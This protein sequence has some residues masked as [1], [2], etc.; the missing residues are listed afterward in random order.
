MSPH[1]AP[2]AAER[3]VRVRL[4]RPT[5]RGA[6]RNLG[7]RLFERYGGYEGALDGWLRHP[8]VV[9]VVA[10]AGRGGPRGF[11][12]IGRQDPGGAPEAYLLAIG[13]DPALQASGWGSALL[14]EAIAQTRRR[15]ARWGVEVLRLDVAES[16]TAGQRLFAR[17]GFVP[18]GP[19]EPYKSGE[20]SIRMQRPL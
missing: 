8:A 20:A 6:V 7:A 9:T 1:D 3:T 18:V 4:M 17:G 15:A 11:A 10:D 13:V 12:L 5:E 14:D 2:A 19:G 16:N